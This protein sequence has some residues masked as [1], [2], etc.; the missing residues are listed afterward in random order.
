M[1]VSVFDTHA[2]QYYLHIT[3]NVQEDIFQYR[4]NHKFKFKT[5]LVNLLFNILTIILFY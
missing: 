3:E 1:N 5:F 4:H 2:D